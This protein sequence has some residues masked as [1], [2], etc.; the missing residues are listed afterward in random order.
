MSASVTRPTIVRAGCKAIAIGLGSGPGS[1]LIAET[2]AAEVLGA[3][4]V[5]GPDQR[6]AAREPW[7]IDREGEHQA[8]AE[9]AQGE[10][11]L[12]VADHRSGPCRQVARG[13][14]EEIERDELRPGRVAGGVDPLDPQRDAPPGLALQVEQPTPDDLLGR[15]RDVGGGHVGVGI[16]SV[17]PMPYPGAI[18]VTTSRS[19]RADVVRGSSIRKWPDSSQRP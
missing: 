2:L 8:A 5:I 14:L 18:A 3:G 16:K 19:C 9:P 15:E 13:L 10:P 1:I 11:A 17:Q 6:L 12:V 7:V 4:I